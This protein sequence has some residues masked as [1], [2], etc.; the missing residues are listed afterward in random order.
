MRLL[1]IMLT[2]SILA[3]KQADEYKT[4]R[5]LMDA[6]LSGQ[7]EHYRFNG[8]VLVAENGEVVFQKSYG[9]AD[10]DTKRPLNDSS[11]F[12]LASVSKQFTATAIL[13]LADKGSLNL[14]DSLRHFFPDLP[15]YNITLWHMLTH[16][17]GLPDYFFAMLEKWDRSKIA[18][19]NDMI[20]LLIEEDLSPEFSPGTQWAYSNTAYVLLASIVEKVSGQS[21]Q[22][23]MAEN[24]FSP[25][26]MHHTRIY[27]TRRS[28]K[29]TIPN[30]AYGYVYSDSLEKYILPDFDK[31]LDFVHY[32]DG[33]QGDGIV[34]STLG[35]LLIWDRSVKYNLLLKPETQAEMLKGQSLVDTLRETYYGFGVL[36][37]NSELGQMVSHGGGWPGYTTWLGRNIDKDQTFILLSNNNSHSPAIGNTLHHILNGE[38]FQMPYK[39]VET[40]VDS[41]ALEPLVGKYIGDIEFQFERK[42]DTLIMVIP[43]RPSRNL[44][45]E[46]ATRFFFDADFDQQL[47]FE[48]GE[49]GKANRLNIIRHGIKT[50]YKRIVE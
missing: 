12:E 10:F 11:V 49:E 42:S 30:Y 17:S 47:A 43:N 23:Y 38:E 31:N 19:N 1:I 29:D 13:L 34:N 6:F 22:D 48:L 26:G 16:T 21:Y 5:E 3:C 36:L 8:N 46:S 44:K 18:F 24:I 9:V 15:Y 28:L 50:E 2:L 27:N 7:V 20:A 33:I 35:D 14:N 39:P 41:L 4:K 32:L 40:T 25:L 45:A 37:E